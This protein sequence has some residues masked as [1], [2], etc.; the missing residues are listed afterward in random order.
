MQ[1]GE[2]YR[3]DRNKREKNKLDNCNSIINEIY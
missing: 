3:E 2:G 1:V